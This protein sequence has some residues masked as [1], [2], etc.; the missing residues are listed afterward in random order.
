ME[1]H[2]SG[3]NA[4]RRLPRL[5]WS[6]I[7]KNIP[8]E[9]E[10]APSLPIDG[11]LSPRFCRVEVRTH[12]RRPGVQLQRA[13]FAAQSGCNLQQA[14]RTWHREMA[15]YARCAWCHWWSISTTTAEHVQRW[16]RRRSFSFLDLHLV[17]V[18]SSLLALSSG[19]LLLSESS[20]S[21]FFQAV[22]HRCAPAFGAFF[23]W[24]SVW[25]K[26]RRSA[27]SWRST[28]GGSFFFLSSPLELPA[29]R[30]EG[31]LLLTPSLVGLLLQYIRNPRQTGRKRKRSSTHRCSPATNK[32]VEILILG[33]YLLLDRSFDYLC[34]SP[35][36]SGTLLCDCMVLLF[37]K[38]P[39]K[40]EENYLLTETRDRK[41]KNKRTFLES[42]W[43]CHVVSHTAPQQT[44]LPTWLDNV[45]SRI[46]VAVTASNR[47][48]GHFT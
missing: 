48:M 27:W 32:V 1:S 26:R 36:N 45:V 21:F 3:E 38:K 15:D 16:R 23:Y 47:S 40:N 33:T 13:D 8:F 4:L 43:L 20:L 35:S 34:A 37:S 17:V 14:G 10:P 41:R 6:P 18:A 5:P 30:L 19:S 31:I 11:R 25:T 2:H 7:G 29:I 44:I 24:F 28:V 42:I 39:S 22:T 12:A 46:D 9:R